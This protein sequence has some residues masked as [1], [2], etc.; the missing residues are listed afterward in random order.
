M[1][2]LLQESGIFRWK[3]TA[4]KIREQSFKHTSYG[5]LDLLSFFKYLGFP[6]MFAIYSALQIRQYLSHAAAIN[7]QST[8]RFEQTIVQ[9]NMSHTGSSNSMQSINNSHSLHSLSTIHH[10]TIR[11]CHIQSLTLFAKSGRH[12]REDAVANQLFV[13]ALL[14]YNSILVNIG[15]KI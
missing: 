5:L 8:F 10:S 2:Y 4:K 3:L 14:S 1:S 6:W 7:L 15:T 9:S 13:F 11:E 12:A